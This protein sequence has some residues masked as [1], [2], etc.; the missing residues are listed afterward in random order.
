V[1]KALKAVLIVIGVIAYLDFGYLLFYSFDPS[2]KQTSVTN[3]IRAIADYNNV[4]GFQQSEGA[5]FALN[6][7]DP[8][9]FFL[10]LIIMFFWPIIL[11][12]LWI[13]NIGH[14]VVVLNKWLGLLR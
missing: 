11:V 8:V 4:V 9:A 7:L 12:F 6:S 1:K 14:Y 2:A 3:F 13:A 5:I 10:Y